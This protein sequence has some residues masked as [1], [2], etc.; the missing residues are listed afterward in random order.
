MV[1]GLRSRNGASNALLQK[2]YDNRITMLISPS[3]FLEYQEVLLR[4]E[5]CLPAAYV[6]DFLSWIAALAKPVEIHFRWRPQLP[7]PSDEMVLEAAINGMADVIVT[8]NIKDFAAA[9]QHFRIKIMRPAELLR[10][11]R[12]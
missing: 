8:H 4:P 7:D 6:E 2:L 11:I 10:R 1:A 9:G 5:H 12:A 3:L